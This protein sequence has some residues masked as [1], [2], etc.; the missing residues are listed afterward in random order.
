MDILE[1]I[2]QGGADLPSIDEGLKR[3]G[4]FEIQGNFFP[5]TVIRLADGR[6]FASVGFVSQ[7]LLALLL[8]LFDIPFVV[9]RQTAKFV[10]PLSF[11]PVEK[12]SGFFGSS[13]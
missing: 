7:L 9:C 5:V 4:F 8:R 6:E 13:S 1:Q 10:K 12:D 11:S 2:L 3:S